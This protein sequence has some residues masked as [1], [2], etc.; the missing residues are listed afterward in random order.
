VVGSRSSGS[1]NSRQI[2]KPNIL[3]DGRYFDTCATSGN[4][5]MNEVLVPVYQ[6][7]IATRQP[8]CE[9]FRANLDRTARWLIQNTYSP[10]NS[11]QIPNPD[12]AHGGAIG[13][14]KVEQVRTDALCHAA[15]SLIGML[16]LPTRKP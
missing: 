2:V 16:R 12:R 10:E 3:E 11:V 1:G 14:E 5:W 8:R 6:R 4:G 15:N 13:K 9:Q 7:C